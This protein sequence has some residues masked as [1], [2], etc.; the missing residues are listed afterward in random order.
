MTVFIEYCG[1][2]FNITQIRSVKSHVWV[3][4]RIP[5]GLT[6]QMIDG[7]EYRLEES[8]T[9]TEATEKTRLFLMRLTSY[10]SLLARTDM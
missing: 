8:G 6:I 4:N 9:V 3:G 10:S 1:H 7:S 5:L 2:Y